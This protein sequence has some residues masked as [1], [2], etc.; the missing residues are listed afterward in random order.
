[1]GDCDIVPLARGGHRLE[2]MLPMKQAT[3]SGQPL[4]SIKVPFKQAVY[5]QPAIVFI[6]KNGQSDRSRFNRDRAKRLVLTETRRRLRL[7]KTM[8]TSA[9]FAPVARTT[10]FEGRQLV[11]RRR[12]GQTGELAVVRHFQFLLQCPAD[13]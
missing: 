10:V 13:A 1:M 7:G 5:A 2:M 6:V 3:L 8:Q 12:F 11:Q 4:C 9:R